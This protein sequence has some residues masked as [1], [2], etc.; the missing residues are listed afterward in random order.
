[1]KAE[2]EAKA[3]AAKNNNT[4]TS[5]PAAAPAVA[6]ARSTALPMSAGK[7][8]L[9]GRRPLAS[10]H[11]N[12]LHARTSLHTP[13]KHNLA[14]SKP[15]ST[16][17]AAIASTA[18]AVVPPAASSSPVTS[19]ALK[20]TPPRP[21]PAPAASP[22]ASAAAPAKKL[23]SI[24][25]DSD[26]SD[27]DDEGGDSSSDE[28][29][30]SPAA[31]AAAGD[32]KKSSSSPSTKPA[33]APSS[34]RAAAAAKP[35]GAKAG[36]KGSSSSA[37][38]ASSSSASTFNL[39][40][41]SVSR[42]DRMRALKAKLSANR[43]AAAA[44]F[45]EKYGAEG[46]A[47]T[48]EEKENALRKGSGQAG[49][50]FL[51]ACSQ[52]EGADGGI[53][54]APLIG[55]LSV[56]GATLFAPER[57]P[58]TAPRSHGSMNSDAQKLV[59][60]RVKA[61]FVVGRRL[62][63]RARAFAGSF[64]G[65]KLLE[66]A[67][68][69]E[70]PVMQAPPPP[71]VK[72]E[73]KKEGYE[74]L[75]I[76]VPTAEE[77]Q[78]NPNLTLVE[79]PHLVCKWLRPHQREGVKFMAECVLGI[80]N[81]GGPPPT[82]TPVPAPAPAPAAPVVPAATAEGDPSAAP[83]DPPA[84]AV[85]VAPVPPAPLP[86]SCSLGAGAILADDMGL[87]KT[88]QSVALLY[89]LL[90]QGFEKG[91]PEALEDDAEKGAVRSAELSA[92]VNQFVLRRTNILLK[93]HLPPK[94]IQIV[95]CRPSA[96]QVQLY[97]HFLASKS[98][99]RLTSGEDEGGSSRGGGGLQALP[100]ITSLK[101]LVNHPKLIFDT[102]QAAASTT[103][104]KGKGGG[105]SF[106]D[107]ETGVVEKVP[108]ALV[109]M[110]KSTRPIF[111]KH[112]GGG[113]MRNPSAAIYSGKMFVLERLLLQ[114]RAS[115]NDRMVIVSNFTSALDVI[116]TMCTL[117]KWDYLRLD[118]TTSIKK[119]QLLVDQLSDHR[120]NKVFVFLLSSRAGGCGLNLIGANRLI[121]FDPDVSLH[122]RDNRRWRSVIS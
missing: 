33:A 29:G 9:G 1:M 6:V 21:T 98:V 83:V 13:L 58:W 14:A 28:E 112:D 7:P 65:F 120:G 48:L 94:V 34:A 46:D 76:W 19:P 12:A 42:G 86:L 64:T 104:G 75:H 41:S 44:A 115:S 102:S 37:L 101:K 39:A 81:L 54:R 47:D 4:N 96:L 56:K 95:C 59:E 68:P 110:F 53:K 20:P 92:I 52:G 106:R 24:S 72:V 111:E 107:E 30:A 87:G 78:A 97:Q 99:R 40:D 116:A 109:A 117:R 108:P 15:A 100:L 27:D 5:A 93:K 8:G 84:P 61:Q 10:L 71:V 11:G 36:K 79:I 3:K 51:G 31:A 82:P 55:A 105:M 114:V 62:G 16:A 45:A 70:P 49:E 66:A 122:K 35:K 74:P 60:A 67:E 85:A 103:K 57:K 119:R 17:G 32:A 18:D 118:G 22:A 91:R 26:D 43:R 113:F 69:P 2:A 121:L 89:T 73:E 77:L 23:P 63:A 25:D 88:L 80:R 50:D 38:P 90:T